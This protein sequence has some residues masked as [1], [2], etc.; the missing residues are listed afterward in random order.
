VAANAHAGQSNAPEP[1]QDPSIVV[2]GKARA[3]EKVI[4]TFVTQVMD[5]QEGQYARFVDPVCPEV[6]GLSPQVAQAMQ[7]RIRAVAAETA[8]PLPKKAKC[9]ANILVM[10]VADADTFMKYMRGRYRMF[11]SDLGDGDRATAFQPGSIRAW[12][13]L[14]LRDDVGA[15]GLVKSARSAPENP[16]VYETPTRTVAVNA[17]VIM[18]KRAASGKSVR[19]LADYAAFRAFTGARPPADGKVALD[20]ILSLFDPQVTPSPAALTASDRGLIASLYTMRGN[21][22]ER[23]AGQQ[24]ASIARRMAAAK[25]RAEAEIAARP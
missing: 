3:A 2:T 24:A 10:F 6:I 9:Q 4:E 21:M 15:M 14:V 1:A 25:A 13:Q 8:V 19:Q 16:P 7:A 20:S 17:V 23:D 22:A 5:A 12:R 18:D 11:F